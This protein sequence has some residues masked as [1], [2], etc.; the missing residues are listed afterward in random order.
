MPKY[1]RNL[2]IFLAVIFVLALLLSPGAAQAASYNTFSI[3]G[4]TITIN[5]SRGSNP[6]QFSFSLRSPFQVNRVAVHILHRVQR[7]ET[8]TSI[9]EDYNVT[10][11]QLKNANNNKANYVVPGQLLRIPLKNTGM[12]AP[13]PEPQPE[14][15]QP[16]PVPEPKPE[17]QPEPPKPDP[18]PEPKPEPQPE[19]KPPA[20]P[21]PPAGIRAEEATMLELVNQERARVGVAP[22]KLHL[23]LSE[24][25]RLK[26][27]D[28]A[29]N[30]Y[31]S[32]QSP[33]Y[34]SPFEMMRSF[35]ITYSMAGENLALAGSVQRAHNALMNSP[36]HRANILNAR[37]THIGIG[38]VQG[39]RG[40]YYTQMFIQARN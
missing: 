9:A 36:G 31:F 39:S 25:A 40:Q 35:G 15:P 1:Q 2:S 14:P 12:P 4:E 16:D 8:L 29:T 20:T 21:A 13:K 30:N 32:H 34:G 18:V 10:P 11:S 27:E 38:M 24:V 5:L 19:P 23:K 3:S 6:L 33:T 17:P 22:L 7:G 26:S 28:M 37:Y